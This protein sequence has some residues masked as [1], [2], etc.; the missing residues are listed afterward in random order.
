MKRKFLKFSLII[1][2]SLGIL[3]S[4]PYFVVHFNRTAEEKA[5][6]AII[7]KQ[8]EDI[9][10]IISRRQLERTSVGDDED[11]FGED[12]IVRV[13]LIGLDSR[14]GQT[15][16]HCDVIQMIEIDKNNNTVNIT[17][18]PRGTYSPLPLGKATTSTDYYVSNACGLAGLNYGINQI[19]KISGKK[20]DYLVMVGFSETL[21][22]LRNLKLPTTETLQWLRQRQ[23]YAIGEPQRARNHSTFIKQL[24][25]KYLPDDHSKID[26]AFHYILYKIIKTDLTFAESEKIV[27]ALIDMDIKNN[28]EKISLS[29]RPSYNVQDIPYDPDTAGEYVKSMI[30]PVKGY[31]KGT[32]YTGI[33]T[34][35]ADQRIVDT[36]DKKISD[37]EFVLWAYENQLWLQIEDDI[38]REE[39]QYE[40]IWQY[41]N[42]VSEEEQQL[43]VADYVLE[44]R[45]LG[46]EDWAV[47]GEDWI[48]A[49][50]T[51]N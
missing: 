26:T 43:I 47:K 19:E 44:M 17:A 25:T 21:G 18:V 12:G 41:L 11:P 14:A 15:A 3:I 30:D 39:K 37:D 51:K 28:P 42:Q 36:I 27:D 34:E 29:M 40:I 49:E 13:L 7:D 50:I 33:T 1:I 5:A 24:L 22:I 45:Y 48:K 35:E 32:S 46:L 4:V 9:K 16:G 23:G 10:E 20:A 38:I 6:Q 31:L 2:I 8:Q